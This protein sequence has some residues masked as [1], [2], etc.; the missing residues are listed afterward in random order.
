MW[1]TLPID[2]ELEL[3]LALR[4]EQALS[5]STGCRAV[6]NVTS[7]ELRWLDFHETRKS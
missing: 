5:P 2:V 4:Y 3:D 7:E 6:T 1:L